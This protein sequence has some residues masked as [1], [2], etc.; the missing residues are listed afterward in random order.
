MLPFFVFVSLL[1]VET[2]LFQYFHVLCSSRAG[3]GSKRRR[4]D[5]RPIHWKAYFDS[6]E[7]ITTRSGQ[8]RVYFSGTVGPWIV[9]L[10]GGGFSALTWACFSVGIIPFR[11][12]FLT[13]RNV[14]S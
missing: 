2:P 3:K 7:M 4:G 12:V 14:E 10:H 13:A 11:I 1:K 8:F 5:L 6:A 9:M